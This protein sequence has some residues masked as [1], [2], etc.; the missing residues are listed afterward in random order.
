MLQLG[1]S[2]SLT[3]PK[4]FNDIFLL[5]PS[6]ELQDRLQKEPKFKIEPIYQDYHGYYLPNYSFWRLEN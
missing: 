5:N 1:K 6:E 2:D 3:I 4:D